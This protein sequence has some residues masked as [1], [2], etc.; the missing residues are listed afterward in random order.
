MN[1]IT[2]TGLIKFYLENL[3]SLKLFEKYSYSSL[4]N[5]ILFELILRFLCR[6]S[7]CSSNRLVKTV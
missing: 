1:Y 5:T 6:K 2:D 4:H 3:C 7:Y